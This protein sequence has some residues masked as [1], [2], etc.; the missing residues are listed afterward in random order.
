MI[1]GLEKN[2]IIENKLIRHI[3]YK[4]FAGADLGGTLWRTVF[5]AV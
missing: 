2:E 4:Y 3:E 1:K 5:S